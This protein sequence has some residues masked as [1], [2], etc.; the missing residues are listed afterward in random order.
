MPSRP[1]NTLP[2]SRPIR[3]RRADLDQCAVRLHVLKW[4]TVRR[5][6]LIFL[7]VIAVGGVTGASASDSPGYGA[8]LVPPPSPPSVTCRAAANGASG[9]ICFYPAQS[10]SLYP[11]QSPYFY[12]AQAR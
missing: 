11:A 8:G 2:R 7:V 10:R 6:I 12:A 3:F 1:S 4:P 9:T 5:L